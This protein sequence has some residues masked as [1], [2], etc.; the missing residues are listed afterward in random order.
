MLF[1][2][3]GAVY[4]VASPL[5]GFLLDRCKRKWYSIVKM[6]SQILYSVLTV[7]LVLYKVRKVEMS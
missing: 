4:A 1:I 2:I 3:D 6:V 5:I 7:V